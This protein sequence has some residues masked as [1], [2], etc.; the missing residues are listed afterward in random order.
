M[1]EDKE[2]FVPTITR[3]TC[4]HDSNVHQSLQY[5]VDCKL[6]NKFPCGRRNEY[7]ITPEGKK[8]KKHLIKLLKLMGEYDGF[9]IKKKELRL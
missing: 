1:S 4:I 5:L 6:L 7:T 2:N 3:Q 9:I 8:A